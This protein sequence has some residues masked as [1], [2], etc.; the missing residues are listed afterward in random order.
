MRISS[1]I[2][3]QTRTR[4][5]ALTIVVYEPAVLPATGAIFAASCSRS[6]RRPGLPISS[7]EQLY[8]EGVGSVSL[9]CP[10]DA[11]SAAEWQAL[12]IRTLVDDSLGLEKEEEKNGKEDDRVHVV[13][14]ES[15]AETAG[16]D[17][18]GVGWER[19]RSGSVLAMRREASGRTRRYRSGGESWS[20]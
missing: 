3:R 5:L 9:A 4:R 20:R 16:D 13:D 15:R 6:H 11:R 7:E 18:A 1:C 19:V 2:Q 10:A 14:Q 8:N 17:V 12:R